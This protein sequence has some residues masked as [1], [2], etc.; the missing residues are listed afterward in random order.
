[1]KTLFKSALALTALALAAQA[2]A[3][4]TVYPGEG[5]RGPGTVFDRGFGDIQRQGYTAGTASIVV[6]NGSWEVCD[7]AG[8]RGRC[9]VLQPGRYPTLGSAGLHGNIASARPYADNS[10]AARAS[11]AT[12]YND[13]GFGGRAVTARDAMSSLDAVGFNDR[14]SSLVIE[15]GSWELCEDINFYGKC[16]VLG[17]GRYGS[18]DVVGLGDRVSSLRPVASTAAMQPAQPAAGPAPGEIVLYDTEGFD[19]RT[20]STREPVENLTRQGFNDRASSIAIRSGIWEVC[21]DARF[22]GRCVTLRA[23]QYPS[24]QS[25]ALNDRISSVRRVDDARPVAQVP[26]APS[27]V[28]YEQEGF[29]GR[30]FT[31]QESLWNLDRQGLQERAASV[32][33]RS[34]RWDVCEDPRFGGRCM[35]LQPGRYPS[36]SSMGLADRVAS[37]RTMDADGRIIGGHDGRDRDRGGMLPAYDARRRGNEP[38]YQAQVTSVREVVG[39][40]DQRCW[41][42]RNPHAQTAGNS[43]PNVGGLLAGG[44]IGGILGHQVGGG[45]GKDLA[46]IGAAIAG[47]AI[48]AN[49]GRDRVQDQAQDIARCTDSQVRG[50]P[51]FWQVTYNFRGVD[52]DLQMAQPPQGTITVNADGEP[53][54]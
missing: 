31:A 38:L 33:V 54:F 12:L 24:L 42:D 48:G 46:T 27:A 29:R 22:S 52:H 10:P 53:R 49:V 7:V 36:L 6:K 9:V 47:A 3:D 14:A 16:V 1:M 5:F 25:M 20:F 21:S 30:S 50:G 26:V 19:G 15:G 18:L 39:P 37:T 8:F 45:R 43:Q 17:P 44:V 11:G 34:G 51:H 35:Q 2:N 13:V 32:D 41:V 28:F 4:V 23:G 40:D